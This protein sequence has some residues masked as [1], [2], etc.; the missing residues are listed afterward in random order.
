MKMLE[1]AEAYRIQYCEVYQAMAEAGKIRKWR[2]NAP[3][4]EEEM[5]DAVSEMLARRIARR[6]RE[7]FK[8]KRDLGKLR[9]GDMGHE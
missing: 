8:L 7:I 4:E 5:L 9:R 3:Y 6:E 1:F 2:K